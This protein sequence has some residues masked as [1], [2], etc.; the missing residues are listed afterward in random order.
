[1]RFR[2]N[3]Y[4]HKVFTRGMEGIFKHC[5]SLFVLR[6]AV[7]GQPLLFP[8]QGAQKCECYNILKQQGFCHSLVPTKIFYRILLLIQH[9]NNETTS[10]RVFVCP[11]VWGIRVIDH[12]HQPRPAGQAGWGS[13][14]HT[15][16]EEQIPNMLLWCSQQ[17]IRTFLLTG[18]KQCIPFFL[19]CCSTCSIKRWAFS[20]LSFQQLFSAQFYP[21]PTIECLTWALVL[22]LLWWDYVNSV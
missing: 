11:A 22:P 6:G 14:P 7:G 19:S 3:V 21:T 8:L 17:G 12:H 18:L 15:T 20:F 16:A 9:F 4:S 5:W 1:M 10:V 2:F 13:A